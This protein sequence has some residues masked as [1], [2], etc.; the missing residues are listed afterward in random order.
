[1]P[2]PPTNGTNGSNATNGTFCPPNVTNVTNFTNITNVTVPVDEGLPDM[3]H[4]PTPYRAV[5]TDARTVEIHLP[6]LPPSPSPSPSAL[7]R[8]RLDRRLGA[9]YEAFPPFL[10]LPTRGSVEVLEP[11]T[12]PEATEDDVRANETSLVL[13]LTGDMWRRARSTSSA[14]RG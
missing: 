9:L 10:P 3:G 7:H 8:R 11:S 12:P 13:R 2:V 5:A 1:M 14:P 4:C 6:P